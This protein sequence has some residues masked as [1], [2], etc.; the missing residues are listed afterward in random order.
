M[1]PN[2]D[3]ATVQFLLIGVST[4]PGTYGY[5]W[6]GRGVTASFNRTWYC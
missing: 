6:E 4:S 5:K 3:K 2:P 1:Y